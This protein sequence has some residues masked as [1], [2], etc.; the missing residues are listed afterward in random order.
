MKSSGTHNLSSAPLIRAMALMTL[1]LPMSHLCAEA[2]D[3]AIGRWEL[4][5][6]KSV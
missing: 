3:P 4:N 1:L 6:A 5:L 2:A